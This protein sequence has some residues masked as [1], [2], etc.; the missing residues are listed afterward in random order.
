[1]KNKRLV[2]SLIIMIL[3]AAGIFVL[4]KSPSAN[5][6][7]ITKKVL[8]NLLNAPNQ[9]L[10]AAYD[11]LFVSTGSTSETAKIYTDGTS[12]LT[13]LDS[14]QL[15]NVVAELLE[16]KANDAFLES[17]MRMNE[18]MTLQQYAMMK[19]IESRLQELSVQKTGQKNTLAYEASLLMSADG[20][21]DETVH[22]SGLVQFDD[23]GNISAVTLN[24][25]ELS[26]I[27]SFE[28]KQ[29]IQSGA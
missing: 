9:E 4:T 11:D 29:E 15:R 7:R 24:S 6:E 27:Y 28:Y 14:M 10:A 8:T 21:A 13:A 1:M 2:F 26:R 20:S 18:I 5:Q 17:C 12:S 25:R 19:G 16:H 23:N 22:I 3:L